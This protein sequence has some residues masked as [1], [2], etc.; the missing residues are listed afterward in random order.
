MQDFNRDIFLSWDGLHVNHCLVLSHVGKISMR[1]IIAVCCVTGV[2]VGYGQ[3]QSF[4]VAI[5]RIVSA[6]VRNA[7]QDCPLKNETLFSEHIEG[8]QHDWNEEMQ[9]YMLSAFFVGYFFGQI[10]GGI[11]ADLLGGRITYVSGVG[12]SS[13][14]TILFPWI[15][16]LLPWYW[17]CIGRMLIG[18]SQGVT[19]PSMSSLIALWV[20]PSERSTLGAFSFASNSLGAVL[21]NFISG[22]VM[23]HTRYWPY[24]F[25]FWGGAGIFWSLCFLIWAY[26]SP[27]KHPHIT[28]REKQFLKAEMARFVRLKVPWRRLLTD[29]GIWSLIIGQIGH[30]FT[31]YLMMTNMPKYFRLYLCSVV[32]GRVIDY[33]IKRKRWNVKWTRRIATWI[34]FLLPNSFLVLMT[35]QECHKI[36]VSILFTLACVLKGPHFAGF[37]VNHMDITVNFNG[38]VMSLINTSGCVG[39]FV[40]PLIVSYGAPNNRLYEWK[41]VAWIIWFLGGFFT[42]YY[43][44]TAQAKRSEWDVPGEEIDEFRAH[45][46]KE[47]AE[48]QERKTQRRE[49]K[50]HRR[51]ERREKTRREKEI[52]DAKKRNGNVSPVP[53]VSPPEM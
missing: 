9:G 45:N 26:D 2:I 53:T 21:G 40:A 23:S 12:L 30:D 28:E 50:E 31:V 37:K 19:Y 13:G 47:A 42:T 43:L 18:I 6:T 44:F 39:G 17:V 8:G 11:S 5:T 38:I 46:A 34:S 32:S 7:S 33:G 27:D 15:I 22:F 35:Y 10:P 41:R 36:E 51:E 20:P 49:A 52:K 24:S 25:F 14:L 48:I 3:R 16:N 29:K 4:N 1:V